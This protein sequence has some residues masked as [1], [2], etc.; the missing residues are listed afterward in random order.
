MQHAFEIFAEWY[1]A[2]GYPVLFLGV[3]LENAG[4]PVPGETAVLIAGF[5]A[6]PAG[7]GRLNVGVVIALTFAA[8]VL[9]DN[10][11]FWLGHRFAR[12]RLRRGRGFLL[13]TPQVF[14]TAEDYFARYGTLTVFLARFIT[15]L[16][17]VAALA[18]GTAGMPWR[19]FVL[20]NAAG[21]LVWATTV[22]L[23][24]Y[25]FGRSWQLLHHWLGWG[26]WIILAC[27]LFI[28]GLRHL[29]IR[30]RPGQTS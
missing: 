18:A 6:S 4:V 2:Y 26:S 19:R 24:G 28:V 27:V 9:G 15:G 3:L 21:A 12:P 16:R 7:G 30:F 1:A 29:W 14:H 13:L 11:G 8:A 5:L 17:V 20:A 10:F 22:S 23:L 25:F